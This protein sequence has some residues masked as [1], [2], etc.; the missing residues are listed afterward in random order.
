MENFKTSQ[1]SAGDSVTL[2]FGGKSDTDDYGMVNYIVMEDGVRKVW[3]IKDTDSRCELLNRMSLDQMFVVVFKP[4]KFK[5][6]YAEI[7]NIDEVPE[8]KMNAKEHREVAQAEQNIKE[9][10]GDPKELSIVTQSILHIPGYYKT[11]QS[12]E[13]NL[14][15]AISHAEHLLKRI[16]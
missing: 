9:V 4:T 14:E 6:P 3:K 15:R 7:K 16:K 2:K 10:F 1:Y 11:D 8:V 13:D 5:Y 12:F